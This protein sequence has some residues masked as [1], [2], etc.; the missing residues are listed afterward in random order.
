M[1]VQLDQNVSMARRKRWVGLLA[2]ADHAS[3][4]R[5]VGNWGAAPEYEC[6][7]GPEAGLVMLR[8][9]AGGT[10]EAFNLGEMTVTR[11]SVRLP[12]GTLGHAYV[13]GRD[14]EHCETAAWLDALLQ[15]P[16]Y[17]DGL[18]SGVIEPLEREA[19]ERRTLAARKTAATRVEFFTMSTGR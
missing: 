12:D 2:K 1:T 4:R 19:D 18:L 17:Q 5:L 13:G 16:A 15:T 6:L 7:R 3:L 9:R 10:G 14:P 11:C 8:G